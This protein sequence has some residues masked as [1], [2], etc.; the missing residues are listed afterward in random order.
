YIDGQKY[1][2]RQ[3]DQKRMT[4]LAR[5]KE[6]LVNAEKSDR[7]GPTTT[8]PPAAP[9]VDDNR[10]PRAAGTAGQASTVRTTT[11]GV[12]AITN[13]TIHPVSRPA[14]D[15]GTIVMRDGIIEGLGANL[16]APSGAQVIDAAGAD[17]Y[18]GLINAQTTMGL[19][20]PGAGSFSDANELL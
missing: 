19:E 9:R 16:A 7:R 10:L 15:R 2:D 17:V 3:D 18:P 14:I 4:E 13:A 20:D 6:S 1:Y 12:L 8:E 5:E 11:R